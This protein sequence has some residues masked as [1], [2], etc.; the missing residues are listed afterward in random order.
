MGKIKH[1]TYEERRA[2]E[3]IVELR[4][5]ELDIEYILKEEITKMIRQ[6][7]ITQNILNFDRRLKLMKEEFNSKWIIQKDRLLA[8]EKIVFILKEE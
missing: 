7:I 6:N 2:F 5:K 8:L 1:L 3:K 4:F